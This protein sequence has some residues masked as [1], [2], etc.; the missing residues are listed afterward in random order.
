MNIT[1]F[2]MLAA[3]G[4]QIG[5]NRELLVNLPSLG[6]RAAV[7][8]ALSIAGSVVALRLTAKYLEPSAGPG[9]EG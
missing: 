5:A 1:L 6:W 9:G 8:S 3:L 2:I 4:A 7:I